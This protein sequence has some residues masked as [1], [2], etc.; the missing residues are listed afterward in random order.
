MSGSRAGLGDPADSV[1]RNIESELHRLD[2]DQQGIVRQ[3]DLLLSARA[4]LVGGAKPSGKQRIRQAEVQR[5][6]AEHP[7]SWPADIAKALGVPATNVSTHLHRG[8]HVRYER[9][10]DGWHLRPDAFPPT[11]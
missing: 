10:D 11:D 1:V 9:H 2:K 8:R 6:L 7:G 5:Y 4:V 3:R